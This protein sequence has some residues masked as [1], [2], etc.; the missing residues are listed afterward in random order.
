MTEPLPENVRQA[1]FDALEELSARMSRGAA[2]LSK[3]AM[4]LRLDDPK[5]QREAL[6]QLRRYQNFEMPGL[7]LGD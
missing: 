5:S 3:Q 2:N 7:G 6:G 1:G 4:R